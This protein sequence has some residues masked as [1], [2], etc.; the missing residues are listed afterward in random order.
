M[1]NTRHTL[2]HAR[3][4]PP[5]TY[6]APLTRRTHRAG[7]P[8]NNLHLA[9]RRLCRCMWQRCGVA[10][11]GVAAALWF[12]LL[13]VGF[14]TSHSALGEG[15]TGGMAVMAFPGWTTREG[16]PRLRLVSVLSPHLRLVSASPSCLRLPDPRCAVAVV[17]RPG[18]SGRMRSDRP[19]RTG[20]CW[21]ALWP[22]GG[23]LRWGATTAGLLWPARI[24]NSHTAICG[25]LV[26][27]SAA[28]SERSGLPFA[29]G[30]TFH[31]S[32]VAV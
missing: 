1:V 27:S 20:R 4:H 23:G 3:G 11:C 8:A 18:Q 28:A 2:L 30:L 9:S 22:S 12:L 6:I 7:R 29:G 5:L 15:E 10:H 26:P 32:T 14:Y 25:S 24:F 13:A 17:S 31:L 21:A 19:R 16:V